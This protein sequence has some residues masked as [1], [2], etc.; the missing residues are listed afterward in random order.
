MPG[1]GVGQRRPVAVDH[2]AALVADDH[3]LHDLVQ[4]GS[5]PV[6]P[7]VGVGHP[8]HALR[9]RLFQTGHRVGQIVEPGGSGQH[10]LLFDAVQRGG[11]PSTSAPADRHPY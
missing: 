7:N 4:R 11:Q 10:A 6:G 2:A 8:G 3:A 9:H 1:P 5:Q